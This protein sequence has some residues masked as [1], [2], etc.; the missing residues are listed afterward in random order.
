V[1]KTT[2]RAAAKKSK[3]PAPK[4]PQAKLPVSFEAA[5]GIREHPGKGPKRGLSLDQI[6]GT[7]V[8]IA[9]SDGLAAVS[10]NRIATE[11]DAATMALYRYVATKD[12]LLMLMVDAA[13][14]DVPAPPQPAEKW[15]AGLSRWAREH[16]DALRRCP[17][18]VRIPIG[19]PPITPNLVLWFERGLNTLRDTGLTE[20]EKLAVLLLVNGFVRNEA[21]L[22]ADLQMATASATASRS[23]LVSLMS[24]YGELLSSLVNPEQFP[25][26]TALIASGVFEGPDDPDENFIFGLER[27]LDGVAGLVR[28]R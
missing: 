22:A 25:S 20:G 19:G 6:V 26:L 10:M 18:V 17:W 9:S 8:D 13:F 21:T 12:E 4:M 11:L 15:R 2:K 14:K 3:R 27:L 7:A 24:S 16:L 5:W 23:K 28:K 1:T